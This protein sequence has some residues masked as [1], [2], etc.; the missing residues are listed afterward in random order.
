MG[1]VF[2]TRGVSKSTPSG[3]DVREEEGEIRGEG[4]AGRVSRPRL[5]KD[6]FVGNLSFTSR[7]FT[8]LSLLNNLRT[9]TVVQ[10]ST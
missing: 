3:I 8:K 5:G 2:M 4:P 7:C 10:S 1:F 6:G 9:I